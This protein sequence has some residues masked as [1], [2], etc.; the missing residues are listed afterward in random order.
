M[1]SNIYR[2][3][4]ERLFKTSIIQQTAFWSVVKGMMGVNSIAVN[5]KVKR[6][7]LLIET[8]LVDTVES[9]VLVIIQHVDANHCV[10]YVP[11]G[12]ELEPSEE[13][14][15][16]FL[17]ELSECLRSYLPAS[18]IMIRYDLCWESY[19]SKDESYFDEDG[20][21][22]GPPS[23]YFQ[24]LRF[25]MST[26][27]RN[28]RKSYSNILP[29]NTIYLNLKNDADTLLMRMKPKT[30]YNIGLSQR[31]GVTVRAAGIDEI[32]TW[33]ALYKETTVR[34]GIFLHDIEYFKV[35]LLARACNTQS[36][37]EVILLL[38]EDGHMPLA[39][40]FLVIT[41]TRGSYLYGASSSEGRNCMATYALQWCA[42]NMAKEKGCTEYDMFGIS[43]RPDPT[44]PMYGLY[45]F[46]N[47][48]GG[49]IFHSLG[50]WDYP[51]NNEAYSYYTSL[52][53]RGQGYHIN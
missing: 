8:N 24:E 28:F 1:L 50:C 51:L 2:K 48:F 20:L 37:A 12:P 47:G 13:L 32:E 42:I 6:D 11:Y 53:L 14:Q 30:R 29:S 5:F 38:A 52:E 9:D 25:N 40:L 26:V 19:W 23:D 36:P 39:A 17:E 3:E 4:P 41:G 49:D 34:N 15:G 45:R 27:N 21:W 43:P 33:Y 10:A 46:K 31:K 35:V 22:N 44:H 16:T 18:C 7:N